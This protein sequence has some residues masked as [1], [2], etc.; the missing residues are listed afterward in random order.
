MVFGF[1]GSGAGG[2]SH[3]A[4]P[5]N[6][7]LSAGAQAWLVALIFVCT[8][9]GVRSRELFSG[10]SNWKLHLFIQSISFL[11][12]VFIAFALDYLW[13]GLGL[14]EHIRLGFLVL[15]ALPTTITGCVILTTAAKGN[16]SAAVVNA[17]LGNL[18]GC[19]LP[20]MVGTSQMG[21]RRK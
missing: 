10:L 3:G 18:L 16:V 19:L 13:A 20:L 5:A 15:S 6:W 11:F 2:V 9:L 21:R 1:F 8:G 14:P 17:C 12:G 4:N 7:G